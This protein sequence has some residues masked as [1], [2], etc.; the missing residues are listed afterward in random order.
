MI[1]DQIYHDMTQH[2]IIKHNYR[3]L[4]GLIFLPTITIVQKNVCGGGQNTKRNEIHKVVMY[5]KKL[6]LM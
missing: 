5:M 6:I 1:Y 2:D 4:N 3:L